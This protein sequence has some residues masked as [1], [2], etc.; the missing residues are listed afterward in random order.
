MT[1]AAERALPVN[2]G[3]KYALIALN[4][5]TDI[6]SPLDLGSGVFA[7]PRGS[8]ELPEHWRKWLGSTRTR[9]IEGCSLAVLVKVKTDNADALDG[10]NIAL[11]EQVLAL[12]WGL[13]AADRVGIASG[14]RVTGANRGDGPD[15]RQV[16]E[17]DPVLHVPGILP[18]NVTEAHLQQAQV[19]ATNL[20]DLLATPGMLRMKLA[21][22]TF[23]QA[24]AETDLGERIHQF[25]RAVDGLTRVFK[26]KE[27]KDKSV[28]LAGATYQDL[29]GQ[30][31]TVRSC[32]EHFHAFDSR[33]DPLPPH[34]AKIRGF[35]YAL[36]AEALARHCLANLVR[37]RH[38]WLHFADDQVETFWKKPLDEQRQ[39]WGPPFD[40]AGALSGF[41]PEWAGRS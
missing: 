23:M 20:R 39:L 11:M 13:L 16:D 40:L 4:A 14:T 33:L 41:D 3:E 29:C 38:L 2:V 9:H 26:G 25:I 37:N 31:Y 12:F 28:L 35:R 24:F 8:I 18:K 7:L 27:F 34:D 19:L 17:V 10:E 22:R 30:L 32:A 21:V 36:A 6:R 15:Y 1:P 5:A